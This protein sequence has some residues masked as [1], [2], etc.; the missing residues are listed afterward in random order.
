MGSSPFFIVGS[1][2]SGSTLL[3]MILASHSRLAIP[4]ET[5]YLRPLLKQLAADRPLH[6]Q[7][8]DRATH[9]ITNHYRWP[10]MKLDPGEFHREVAKFEAP[11]LRDVV[12]VVYRKHLET[13]HKF[14]WGDKTPGYIEIMPQLRKL[15]PGSQFIHLF[16]DGR[17]VAKSFHARRW[18]GHWLHENTHE[19]NEA[20]DYNERWSRSEHSNALLQVRYEDLVLDTESTVRKICGF[21]DEPFEPQ[22]LAWQEKVDDLIPARE[23][24]IHAKLKQNPSAENVYRWKH[25]MTKLELLVSE[26]FMGGR[27]AKAGYECRYRSAAWAPVFGLTR[28]YCRHVLPIISHSVRIFRALRK[29]LAPNQTDRRPHPRDRFQ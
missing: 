7:E 4:P 25:E 11:F 1:G 14:R 24:H 18:E 27:L 16:R 12:E 15:F 5:W 10:D 8:V 6:P 3:R 22:M 19:W 28:L 26:A 2:R 21:L 29:R 20:M 13:E 9:I 17:D 23:A